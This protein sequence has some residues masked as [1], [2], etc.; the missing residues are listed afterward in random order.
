MGSD[1]QN[2]RGEQD[3]VLRLVADEYAKEILVHLSEE[4]LS[5]AE[6]DEVCRAAEST[7]YD[8]LARL[9]D[10]GLVT[11]HLQVDP[12][13]H[14]RNVYGIRVDAVRVEIR[15]GGYDVRLQVREDAADRIAQMWQTVRGERE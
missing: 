6:L 13:G 1:E 14:H 15:N 3:E 9:E 8:R 10:A 4:R 7:V 11:E 12:G 5:A 2:G